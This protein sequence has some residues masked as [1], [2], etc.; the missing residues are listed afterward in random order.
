MTLLARQAGAVLCFSEKLRRE[1]RWAPGRMPAL[2]RSI[3]RYIDIEVVLGQFA[4]V[5]KLKIRL[6]ALFAE[7]VD[8]GTR[9]P[10]C[11]PYCRQRNYLG[12]HEV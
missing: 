9:C 3:V 4:F 11:A 6:V 10:G 7:L 5:T 12:S 8:R 1:C 2:L